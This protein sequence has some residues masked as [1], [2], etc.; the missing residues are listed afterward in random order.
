VCHFN[1]RE[2]GALRKTPLSVASK[3]EGVR[4][5]YNRLSK[6]PDVRVGDANAFVFTSKGMIPCVNQKINRF[7]NGSPQLFDKSKL[8]EILAVLVNQ[9][10]FFYLEMFK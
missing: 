6:A 8:R 1:E 10:S 5:S 4:A 3:V 2:K 7:D 9:M